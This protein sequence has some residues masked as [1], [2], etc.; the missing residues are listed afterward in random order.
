M[1]EKHTIEEKIS[2]FIEIL[3][4]CVFYQNKE[5]IHTELTTNK[6]GKAMKIKVYCMDAF[7]RIVCGI[8]T[9]S[10]ATAADYINRKQ[11]NGLI[12]IKTT[13]K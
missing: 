8:V 3:K 9:S 2:I 10:E 13:A 5:I 7:G 1:T 11:A 6:E 4:G 12:T